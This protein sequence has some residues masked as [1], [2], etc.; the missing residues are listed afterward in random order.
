MGSGAR[1]A[2]QHTSPVRA[3]TKN[4]LTRRHGGTEDRCSL[5]PP[6]GPPTCHVPGLSDSIGQRSVQV[7]IKVLPGRRSPL[8]ATWDGQ[9]VNFALF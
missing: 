9:G 1:P 2:L 6:G 5:R 7:D 8:G 4:G 3:A